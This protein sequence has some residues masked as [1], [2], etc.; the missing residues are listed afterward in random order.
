MVKKNFGRDKINVIDSMPYSELIFIVSSGK[1]Y[2]LSI[3]EARG[4]KDS[5]PTAKQ[6][7]QLVERGFLVSQ[8]EKFLNKTIYSVDY[9]KIV[10]EFIVY[11]RGLLEKTIND[12]LSI[13][14]DNF[15][16]N[17]KQELIN[18]ETLNTKNYSKNPYLL[19]FFRELLS[20]SVKVGIKTTLK[21]LFSEIINR[22]VFSTVPL[23]ADKNQDKDCVAVLRVYDIVKVIRTKMTSIPLASSVAVM[24][25]NISKNNK[26]ETKLKELQE[27]LKTSEDFSVSIG[28]FLEEMINKDT[29]K[30]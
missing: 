21:E 18:N 8:K 26:D 3:A 10:E 24:L 29:S 4:K 14:D 13:S 16:D 22:D 6:L 20:I 9:E 12:N 11:L 15:A 17:L 28:S 19:S 7:N 1:N 25:Y 30:E 2:P 23:I 5:S 27:Y